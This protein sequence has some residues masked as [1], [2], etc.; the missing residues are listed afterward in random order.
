[1]LMLIIA[2][3]ESAVI[4]YHVLFYLGLNICLTS[5]KKTQDMETRFGPKK[6][7]LFLIKL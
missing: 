6:K 1:M 2:R 3:G 4:D 7:S 5:L